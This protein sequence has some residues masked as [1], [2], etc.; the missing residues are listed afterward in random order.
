MATHP[1]TT[2]DI[3]LSLVFAYT[4]THTHTHTHKIIRKKNCHYKFEYIRNKGHFLNIL[5]TNNISDH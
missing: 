5:S 4:H 1:T 2:P 3:D